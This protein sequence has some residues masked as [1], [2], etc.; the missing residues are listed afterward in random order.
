MKVDNSSL[1]GESDALLRTVDCTHPD[2]PLE[3][4]NLAFFGTLCKEGSGKGVV[5]QTGD[6]TIIGEIAKLATAGRTEETPLTKEINRFIKGMAAIAFSFG[7]TF[8]IL[9]FIIGYPAVNNIAFAIGIIVA[10]LPEGLLTT[11]TVC[12]TLAAQ[13]LAVAKVLV[14]NLDS[15]ETL[16]S[17]TVICSDKTGTL[18]QNRMTAANL[19][20]DS[21]LHKADNLE[22]CGPNFRYEYDLNCE[23]F[24]DLHETA[25]LGSEAIFSTGTPSER[26]QVLEDMKDEVKK[27]Q[28]KEKIDKQY[29]KEISTKLWLDKPALGDASETGLIKFFQPIEDIIKTRERHRTLTMKDGSETKMP[30]NSTNKFAINIVEYEIEDSHACIFIKVDLMIYNSKTNLII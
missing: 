13:R 17:T 12:I 22:K 5:I 20:Y 27:A 21:N 10:N 14:K 19:W 8:F 2:H 11:L 1:T 4:F 25:V 26:L 3:T 6:N 15:V 29:L 7:F 18:T 23:G 28:E 24:K 16:G 30:F 9:G